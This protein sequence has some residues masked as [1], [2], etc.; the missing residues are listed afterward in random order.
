MRS[1]TTFSTSTSKPTSPTA[2]CLAS[3]AQHGEILSRTYAED[4]VS[5]HCRM[6]RKFLGQLSPEEA[7]VRLR[8]NGQPL[9]RNGD[10][11]T[12]GNAGAN[13]HAHGNGRAL[14]HSAPYDDVA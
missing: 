12:N 14:R 11:S 5:V 1:R 8:S 4:R 10:E 13:G 2:G 9:D 6:P 7:S 3:L